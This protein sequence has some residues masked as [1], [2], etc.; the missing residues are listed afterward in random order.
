MFL[1]ENLRTST[2]KSALLI[3][4]PK[5]LLYALKLQEDMQTKTGSGCRNDDL[6][7]L[8]DTGDKT[9]Y[10]LGTRRTMARSKVTPAAF[11]KKNICFNIVVCC[12]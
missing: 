12:S 4:I 5:Y 6:F 3:L 9:D 10:G 11:S 7:H 8:E 2:V 1:Y